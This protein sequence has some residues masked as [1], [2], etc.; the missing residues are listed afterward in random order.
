[1]GPVLRHKGASHIDQSCCIHIVSMQ[2]MID[3]LPRV[4]TNRTNPT[5]PT[6]W[7]AQE[8]ERGPLLP[9]A[10]TL[11]CVQPAAAAAAAHAPC[12]TAHLLPPCAH[13]CR[14]ARPRASSP[15]LPAAQP[16]ELPW[17]CAWSN[18][19]SS[20]CCTLGTVPGASGCPA[21]V[22]AARTAGLSVQP[23]LQAAHCS[24]RLAIGAAGKRTRHGVQMGMGL[25]PA[26]P[27]QGAQAACLLVQAA[28][29]AAAYCWGAATGR[30]AAAVA[31]AMPGARVHAR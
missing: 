2:T 25:L 13:S 21:Q 19:S 17:R 1:M 11:C 7:P 12:C 23:V 30:W 20:S 8:H 28:R 31:L 22:P 29:T 27:Q 4:H 15:A 5:N 10:P 18:S 9:T 24:A 14:R 26:Q 3:L 6:I 16:V